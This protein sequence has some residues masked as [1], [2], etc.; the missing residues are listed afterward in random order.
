MSQVNYREKEAHFHL[1][2]IYSVIIMILL[3]V[4]DICISAAYEEVNVKDAN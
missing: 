2:V 4:M 3:I 1:Q